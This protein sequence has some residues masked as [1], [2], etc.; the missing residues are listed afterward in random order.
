MVTLT[1]VKTIKSSPNKVNTLSL[2]G[3]IEGRVD[4]SLKSIGV[5]FYLNRKR[6][7]YF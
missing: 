5:R 1:S 6:Y 2:S 7:I 3:K 4:Q